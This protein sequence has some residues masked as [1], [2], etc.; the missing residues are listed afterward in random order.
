[1]PTQQK[2]KKRNKVARGI[3]YNHGLQQQ[4]ARKI[5]RLMEDFNKSVINITISTL[6]DK[7]YIGNN[8]VKLVQDGYFD[9]VRELEKLFR[10]NFGKWLT[11]L[12]LKAKDLFKWFSKRATIDTVRAQRDALIKAGLGK[13]YLRAK[14]TVPITRGQYISPQAMAKLEN[15]IVEQTALITKI[16]S[17]ELTHLQDYIAESLDQGLNVNELE[18][19]LVGFKEFDTARAKRVAIDQSIKI[20][21]NIQRENNLSLGLTRAVWI[22]VPGQWYSRESHEKLN[23]KEYELEKGMW[24]PKTQ[25]HIQCGEL[26]YCRCIYRIVIPETMRNDD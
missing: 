10:T 16:G 9:Y 1:M 23:G 21:Q 26:P 18:S 12:Q 2:H 17:Q 8:D 20:N 22:H 14:W 5:K 7:G 13:Q 25:K 19:V 15:M 6:K 3:E 4:L 11:A 24:D